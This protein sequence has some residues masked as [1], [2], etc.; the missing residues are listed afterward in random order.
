MTTTD[1]TP[2]ASAEDWFDRLYAEADEVAPAAAPVAAPRRARSRLGAWWERRDVLEDEVQDEDEDLEDGDGDVLEDE[3]DAGDAG[4]EESGDQEEIA[5]TAPADRR[6]MRPAPE[7]YPA[8]PARRAPREAVSPGTRRLIYNAAAAGAGYLLGLTP[9][10]GGWIE[11]CGETT[12]IGG[13]LVLGC[14]ICGVVAHVWDRR[15][16]HWWVGLAWL[17][18][19]PLASSLTALALYAPASQI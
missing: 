3:P 9:T 12:S 19:I 14:G 18:R 10:V 11:D 2:V 13:A 7:Y 4:P 8:P 15:T 17:A 16:R 1:D 5:E 6:W